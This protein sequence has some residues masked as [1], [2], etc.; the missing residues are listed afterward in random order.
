MKVAAGMPHVAGSLDIY[1]GAG[2]VRVEW[3][4]QLETSFKLGE[5]IVNTVM[6]ADNEVIVAHTDRELWIIKQL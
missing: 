6:C 5:L 1:I 2:I 3:Q 4:S